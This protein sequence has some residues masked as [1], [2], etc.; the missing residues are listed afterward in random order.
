MHTQAICRVSG[1]L[2]MLFSLTMLVPLPFA[3]FYQEATSQTFLAA[4]LLTFLSGLLVWAPVARSNQELRTREGFLITAVFYTSLGLFGALPLWL[5]DGAW[6]LFS[7]AA[8]ESFSGLTTTGATVATGLDELPRSVLFYRQQLQWLGGM[9]IIILAVA[10]LPMLG[11]GG[12]QL[13]RTEMPGPVKDTKLTPRIAET[14]KALWYIYLSLTAACAI[15]YWIAGM[16][17]FDALAHSLSTVALGGY[18]TYDGSIGHFDSASIEAVGILFMVLCGINFGLHFTVWNRRAPWL[19]LADLEVRTYLLMLVGVAL[20][21]FLVLGATGVLGWDDAFRQTTFQA[22][23][24]GTTAGFTTTDFSVWPTAVALLVFFAAFT[25]ACA[26]STGG[27]IKVVRVVLIMLQGLREIRRLIHPNAL[28]PVKLGASVVP[29]RVVDAIWGFFAAWVLIFILMMFALL[30]MGLD[31]ITAFSAVGACLTNLGPGLGDVAS[32][33]GD[34]PTAAKWVLCAAML[35]GRLE[36]F[37]LLVLLTP[38]FWR[39]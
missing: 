22:I 38:A 1:L 12:M 34:L 4:F 5:E 2:L 11:V 37:T 23:S 27:G 26:G 32:H 14:A 9:G 6:A 13:Y 24:I 20:I 31:F 10:I 29:D 30:F 15:A 21:S 39:G 18:S 7:D 25:G 3:W 17:V 16:G 8:F 35:L 19:Y 28:V 36:L 33:Y